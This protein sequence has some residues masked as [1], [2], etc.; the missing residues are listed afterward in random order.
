MAKSEENS[1]RG[2][3]GWRNE[4]RRKNKWR[5]SDEK[6][7]RQQK[8]TINDSKTEAKKV[9]G[10]EKK[11][12][13]EGE[14][15]SFTQEYITAHKYVDPFISLFAGRGPCFRAFLIF[16]RMFTNIW[17]LN[18]QDV[19]ELFLNREEMDRTFSLFY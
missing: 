16:D 1:E 12:E 18:L 11:G 13:K 2:G 17:V 8:C 9:N 7:K 5:K 6:G 14:K 19:Y 3:K 4:D 15:N 10:R